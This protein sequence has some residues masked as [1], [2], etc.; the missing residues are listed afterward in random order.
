MYSAGLT[1]VVADGSEI[2]ALL[3][4]AELDRRDSNRFHTVVSQPEER[5]NLEL[6]WRGT[7]G[8]AR[9]AIGVGADQG[10]RDDGSDYLAGRGFVELRGEL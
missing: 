1:L 9:L 5:W 7:L 2:N 3:R 10:K 6:S 8:P 4:R